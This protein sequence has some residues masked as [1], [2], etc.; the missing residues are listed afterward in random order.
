MDFLPAEP[1]EH[2][3]QVE[4]VLEDDYPQPTLPPLRASGAK[5]PA[6][7]RPRLPPAADQQ[8]EPTYRK[9]HERDTTN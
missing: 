2:Q 7:Y 9:N 5:E 3:R 4:I 8:Q 6:Y 1:P